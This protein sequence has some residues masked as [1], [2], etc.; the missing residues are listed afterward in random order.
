VHLSFGHSEAENSLQSA[1]IQQ[2]CRVHLCIALSSREI[3]ICRWKFV[4]VSGWN[5]AVCFSLLILLNCET[6]RYFRNFC[7]LRA[8]TFSLILYPRRDHATPVQKLDGPA[9]TDVTLHKLSMG[10]QYRI[11]AVRTHDL[12][13]FES[14][15]ILNYESALTQRSGWPWSTSKSLNPDVYIW[16]VEKMPSVLKAISWCSLLA[17]EESF[18]FSFDCT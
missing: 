11:S 15:G 7:K 9:S 13:R 5:S 8:N 6:R 16:R 4:N 1:V 14:S 10:S 18:R 2:L 17:I 3:A 12:G